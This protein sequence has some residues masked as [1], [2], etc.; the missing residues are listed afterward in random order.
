MEDFLSFAEANT[1]SA[2]AEAVVGRGD[3]SDEFINACFALNNGEFSSVV[4]AQV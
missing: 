4:T 1:E 3:M 2:S